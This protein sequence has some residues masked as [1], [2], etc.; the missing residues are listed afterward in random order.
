MPNEVQIKEIQA[1]AK[2]FKECCD[3]ID[4]SIPNEIRGHLQIHHLAYHQ[5]RARFFLPANLVVK[6]ISVVRAERKAGDLTLPT[7]SIEYDNKTCT[8][9]SHEV[10]LSV[11]NG[12]TKVA[13]EP[14]QFIRGS[15]YTLHLDDWKLEIIPCEEIAKWAR[16]SML[17]M[18][19]ITRAKSDEEKERLILSFPPIPKQA[20]EFYPEI[21]EAI[22]AGNYKN[23]IDMASADA[24]KLFFNR[25]LNG[26]PRL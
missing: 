23:A 2:V 18:G 16:A 8:M 20:V 14:H 7:N 26:Y 22:A 13:C 5:A 9:R 15:R 17:L 21:T 11:L 10:S 24:V 6:A 1:T 19:K 12:R 3:W 4:E 25:S